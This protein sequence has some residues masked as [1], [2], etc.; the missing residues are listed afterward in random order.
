MIIMNKMMALNII[1]GI[2]GPIIM[3]PLIF[4]IFLIFL[5]IK[6]II[7]LVKYKS[8]IFLGWVLTLYGSVG[9]IGTLIVKGSNDYKRDSFAGYIGESNGFQTTVDAIFAVAIV[10]L[11][12]GIVLLIVGYMRKSQSTVSIEDMNTNTKLCPCCGEKILTT[13]KKCKHCG[14]WLENR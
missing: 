5:I 10:I 9:F 13:A 6:G 11:I 7:R 1:L 12:I 3:L 2:P 4:L 8:P 14:E